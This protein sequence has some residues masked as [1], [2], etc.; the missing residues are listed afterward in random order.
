GLVDLVGQLGDDDAG[1]AVA[2]LLH[3]GTGPHLDVALTG[4]VGGPAARPAHEDTPGRGVGD[5]DVPQ[6]VVQG[7]VDVGQHADGGVNDLPQVVGRDVGG[8]A[9]GDAGRAVDQQVG[10]ARGEHP[11]LFQGLV[12]VGVPVHGV[13]V[14]VSQH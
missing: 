13:L 14:D 1:A 4:G 10:E 11:G 2:E 12:E 3:L 5:V 8:H 9:H 6:Q 7:G